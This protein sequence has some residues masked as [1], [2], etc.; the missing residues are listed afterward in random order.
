MFV[1]ESGHCFVKQRESC[2]PCARGGHGRL[3]LNRNEGISMADEHSEEAEADEGG[4]DGGGGRGAGG[5]RGEG[6][7]RG[8][9]QGGSSRPGNE[10]ISILDE[11]TEE[12]E[13]NGRRRRSENETWKEALGAPHSSA[14]AGFIGLA[15]D[16]QSSIYRVFSFIFFIPSSFVCVCVCVFFPCPRRLARSSLGAD[17]PLHRFH[18]RVFFVL[19]QF[20]SMA[21]YRTSLDVIKIVIRYI[22][23][24]LYSFSLDS[25]VLLISWLGRVD[26]KLIEVESTLAIGD[27][28][29]SLTISSAGCFHL[30]RRSIG[31]TIGLRRWIQSTRWIS[32]APLVKRRQREREREREREQKKNP[33]GHRPNRTR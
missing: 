26:S 2:L 9:G 25:V 16:A 32:I 17:V 10:G 13:K 18:Y 27:Q 8:E 15:R 30:R 31:V 6:R 19:I 12:E 20:L 5:C 21:H 29:G 4:G 14:A 7:M 23:R 22:I 24:Y 33:A 28:I 1:N 11:G 3:P